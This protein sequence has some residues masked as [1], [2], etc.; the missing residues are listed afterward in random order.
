MAN[1]GLFVCLP[2]E[3]TLVFCA[4]ALNK[5]NFKRTPFKP[6]EDARPRP[7]RFSRDNTANIFT[8]ALPILSDCEGAARSL[9]REPRPS[10]DGGVVRQRCEALRTDTSKETTKPQNRSTVWATAD[11]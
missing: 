7:P 9:S 3:L 6:A 8:A 2:A 10:V 5:Q 11:L 1:T 4:C